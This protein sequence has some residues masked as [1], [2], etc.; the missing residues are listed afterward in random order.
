[1]IA[2]ARFAIAFALS[3]SALPVFPQQPRAQS[4]L[5]EIQSAMLGEWVLTF[6]SPGSGRTRLTITRVSQNSDGSFQI[7]GMLAHGDNQTAALKSGLLS[8]SGSTSHLIMT[9]A[10]GSLLVA[11]SNGEG[12]F[13]GEST[14]KNGRK[15]PF[16]ME[17]AEDQSVAAAAPSQDS[18]NTRGMAE[19]RQAIERNPV[20]RPYVEVGDCWTYRWSYPT[21]KNKP[22]SD[23]TLCVTHV[24]YSKDVILAVSSMGGDGSEYSYTSEWN[25][26]ADRRAVRSKAQFLKFPLHVGDTY[27]FDEDYQSL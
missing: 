21:K 17:K 16:K 18:I 25:P 7:A 19:A 9:T 14:L 10:L 2:L 1:M 5:A 27:S 11:D 23:H 15:F 22:Y 8:Q 20:K 12:G 6:P 24:D 4:S 3:I 26:V 13:Q